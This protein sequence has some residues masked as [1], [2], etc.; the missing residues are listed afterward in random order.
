MQNYD[1][2]SVINIG[3]GQEISIKDLAELIKDIVGYEGDLI[4]DDSKPDGTPRK[5]CDVTKL[6]N[7]GWK[8]K[9]S[10][11]KGIEETYAWYINN[12]NSDN[13][14]HKEAP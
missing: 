3:S 2:E 9:T 13:A 7:L 12:L 14:S 1:D 8:S 6:N 10:L 4:F 5:F 11:E